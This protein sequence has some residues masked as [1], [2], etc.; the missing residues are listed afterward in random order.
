[1]N[2]TL[3]RLESYV[4]M[5]EDDNKFMKKFYLRDVAD[6]QRF[7]NKLYNYGNNGMCN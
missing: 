1:M 5:F 7:L 6:L 2:D 3:N 4:S